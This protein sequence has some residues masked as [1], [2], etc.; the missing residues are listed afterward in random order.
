[1]TKK[2]LKELRLKAI[3]ELEFNILDL[4]REDAVL[5]EINGEMSAATA[6]YE[7]VYDDELMLVRRF[8]YD[9]LKIIKRT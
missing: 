7:T 1:M 5:A 3:K 9:R 8:I 6:E 2:L 4:V